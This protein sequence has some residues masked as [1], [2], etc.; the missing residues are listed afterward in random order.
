MK[1]IRIIFIAFSFYLLPINIYSSIGIV[2]ATSL[3]GRAKPSLT[4]KRLQVF[5]F[6]MPLEFVQKSKTK[7]KVNNIL[8]FWYKE[9]KSGS[10]LFGRYLYFPKK[11]NNYYYL[12]SKYLYCNKGEFAKQVDGIALDPNFKGSQSFSGYLL[13]NNYFLSACT[14]NLYPQSKKDDFYGLDFGTYHYNK[15]H[16]YLKFLYQTIYDQMVN[17][18]RREMSSAD[19]IILKEVIYKKTKYFIDVESSYTIQTFKEF[20]QKNPKAP[21]NFSYFKLRKLNLTKTQLFFPIFRK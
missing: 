12:E 2:N 19:N 14:I 13:I 15:G 3:S 1:Y 4:S 8:D 17:S 7:I 11:T 20:C 10:W 16:V 9:K 5:P 21:N 6:G 18:K